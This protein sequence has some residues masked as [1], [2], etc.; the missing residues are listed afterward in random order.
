FPEQ[1]LERQD[2]A[3]A[4]QA[5]HVL[6]KDPRRDQRQHGLLAADDQRVPGVVTALEAGHR[7]GALGQQVDDLALAL[8][9]P[10]GADDDDEFAHEGLPKKTGRSR[11]NKM[12]TVRGTA[13]PPELFSLGRRSL[14]IAEELAVGRHHDHVALAADRIP[15]GLQA[16]IERVELGVPVVGVGVELRSNGVAFTADALRVGVRLGEDLG[17]PALG[18]GADDLRFAVA[19]AALGA[20]DALEA[21]LHALVHAGGDVLL[22]VDALQAHVDQLD[23]ELLQLVADACEETGDDLVAVRGHDLGQLAPGDGV[24]D[25]VLDFLADEG[26]GAFF[27]ATAGRL[28]VLLRVADA[29]LDVVIDVQ[30]LALAGEE[31]LAVELVRQHA[32]VELHD[33]VDQ[34]HLEVQAGLVSRADDGVDLHAQRGLPLLHHERR[35]GNESD[36]GHYHEQDAEN[37]RAHQRST[38]VRASLTEE[39]SG[40]TVTDGRTVPVADASGSRLRS[41]SLSS[42]RYNRLPLVPFESMMTLRELRSTLS[43]VSMYMRSRV[44]LGAFS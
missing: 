29:P 35:H 31:L 14:E 19:L 40:S 2:H 16:A 33:V 6:V 32:L 34:R 17:A 13:R 9:A 3:V 42:G 20:R 1:R 27:I 30:Q 12:K 8:V 25:A 37:A 5:L 23:A 11:A 10:L 4:D 24:L 36:D 38:R 15:I 28:V 43:T 41:P 39:V 18:V 44:T 26:L 22:Q 21:L 7:G